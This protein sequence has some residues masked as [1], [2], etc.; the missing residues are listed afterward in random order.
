VQLKFE[1][2][3]R[4]EKANHWLYEIE[5]ASNADESQQKLHTIHSKL[6]EEF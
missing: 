5:R 4:K 6:E 1:I 2:P 3:E